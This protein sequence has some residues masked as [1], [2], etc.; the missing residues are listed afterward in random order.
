MDAFLEED[1]PNQNPYYQNTMCLWEMAKQLQFKYLNVRKSLPDGKKVLV[2]GL[3]GYTAPLLKKS[4]M[5]YGGFAFNHKFYFDLTTWKETPQFSYD[6]RQ[7]AMDR[8]NFL[9]TYKN[10]LAGY[11]FAVDID[12]KG[13]ESVMAARDIA[14]T[15]KAVLDENCI[16]YSL[17]FSGNKGF[18]F[19]TPYQYV[20]KRWDVKNLPGR[21]ADAVN[22]IAEVYNIPLASK[23]LGKE[24][25]EKCGHAAHIDDSIYDLRRILAIAYGCDGDKVALPLSDMQFQNFR[26]EDMQATQ[27]LQRVKLYNRGLLIRTHG[28]NEKE[29]TANFGKLLQQKIV[30]PRLRT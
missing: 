15:F 17:K 16:P 25:K 10:N 19:Y 23:C 20:S 6:N 8:E 13:P 29:L 3:L 2:R 22:Y 30:T 12:G 11:D 1:L 26:V 14:A 9:A 18:H 28:M 24:A 5:H 7:R 4:V 27:V 21:M